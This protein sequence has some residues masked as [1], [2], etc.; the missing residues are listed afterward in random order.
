[1]AGEHPAKNP[2]TAKI[3][4]IRERGDLDFISSVRG[5]PA[6]SVKHA[7]ILVWESAPLWKILNCVL[8]TLFIL[9]SS[10]D[11]IA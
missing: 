2:D 6:P 8:T 5:Q 7:K 11:P 1:M 10:F 3:A 4:V 9:Q